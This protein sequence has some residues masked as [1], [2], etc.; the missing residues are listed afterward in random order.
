MPSDAHEGRQE[1]LQ[2]HLE[3]DLDRLIPALRGERHVQHP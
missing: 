3:P 2:N 1:M